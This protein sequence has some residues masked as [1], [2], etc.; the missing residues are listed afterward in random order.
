MGLLGWIY[1]HKWLLAGAGLGVCVL[2]TARAYF[3]LSQFKG[4]FSTGFSQLWHIR[5]LL[6]WKPQAKYR[7]V[8][9]KYGTRKPRARLSMTLSLYICPLWQELN[10]RRANTSCEK[11]LLRGSGRMTWSRR[12]RSSSSI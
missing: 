8:C 1:H 12:P 3:R 4:P 6:S 7:Q 10:S 2:R 9:D 11:A 5:A